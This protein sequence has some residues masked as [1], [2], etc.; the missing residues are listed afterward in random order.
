MG[1]SLAKV[2]TFKVIQG[3]A[4]SSIPRKPR[5]EKA[6]Q[7]NTQ[8][9]LLRSTTGGLHLQ[10]HPRLHLCSGL[11]A[12]SYL[13]LCSLLPASSGVPCLRLPL[14]ASLCRCGSLYKADS[15]LLSSS[16]SSSQSKH[17]LI[18]LLPYGCPLTTPF[19]PGSL[20][21]PGASLMGSLLSSEHPIL[22]ASPEDG[23]GACDLIL[24]Y[25]LRM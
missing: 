15:P 2:R 25:K 20:Q 10:G 11:P 7:P 18:R 6:A 1:I 5:G 9:R 22:L 14:D 23:E 4:H 12:P 19:F 3:N 13:L 24:S 8:E 17:A 16:G 21:A